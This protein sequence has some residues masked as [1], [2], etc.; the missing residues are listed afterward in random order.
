[1]GLEARIR[2]LSLAPQELQEGAV[3]DRVV[4]G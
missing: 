3:R 2:I 1:M 4:T